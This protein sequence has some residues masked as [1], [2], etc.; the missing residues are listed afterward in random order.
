MT[1]FI[2]YLV[3]RGLVVNLISIFLLAIGIYAAASINR[4]AFPNVNLDTILVNVVY[5]G[6][7]PKEVEQLVVTPI[8]QELRTINGIDKMVSMSFPGSGRITLE[9]DPDAKNRDLLTSDISLAVSRAKLPSELPFEPTVL[10]IDGAIFPIIRLALSAPVSDLELKRLSLDIRDD[11]LNVKG[12]AKVTIL[13][14]RKAEIRIEVDPKKLAQEHISVTDIQNAIL[15]WNINTAGGDISTREGQKVVRIVGEFLTPE[16]A[17]NLVIRTNARGDSLKVKDVATV[18]ESLTVPSVTYDVGGQPGLSMLVL[19][20]SDADIINTVDRVHEY[21]DTVHEVYGDD[22]NINGFQDFSKF[23]RMRLGVL[24]NNGKVGL[25]LVFI[26]LLFFLRFSV[27]MMA[28]IG[29]PIIFMSGI[30]LLYISGITLN[31]ISM[32]GFIMV[33]GMLVDDAILI[34]ENITFHMEKGM[35]PKM[36]AVTGTLELIGPVT[37]SILTTIAAFIPMMFMSGIIGKF[38]ISIPIVVVLM[39]TLSWL[40]TFFILPSHVA[41]FTNPDKH[42]KERAWLVALDTVYS[43]LLTAVIKFRWITVGLSVVVLVLA[44]SL[45]KTMPFQLFPA[46][47]VEEFM[48]RVTAKPGTSLKEMRQNMRD[49]NSVLI[50]DL[51]PEHVQATLLTT[52]EISMDQGDPLT[53]RGSRYGQIR[54]IYSSAVGRPNHDVLDDMQKAEQNVTAQF[55]DLDIAFTA[56]QPGPPLGRP[57]EAEISSTNEK[58]SNA[59]AKKLIDYLDKIDGITSIDSGLKRG[60]DEIHVVLDRELATYAGVN[61]ASAASV[62]RAATGGLVVSY[63]HKDSEEIDITIR[64]PES[65]GNGL[66]ILKAIQIPNRTDGLVPLSKIAN[67]EVKEGFTTIR[68]KDAIRIVN[69]T[70]DIDASIITSKALNTLV[71]ENE[72][73]WLGELAKSVTVN[74]G[75]EEEKNLES[76]RSLAIAFMFALLAIFFILAIQFN[77]LAYPLIVML[78][79]PFGAIGIIFSVYLHDIFWKPMPLSF[80]TMLGMVALTGVVVNSSLILLVFIQRALKEGIEVTKAIIT[81]GRRRLRAVLLTATTTIVGLLPTAYGWGGSDPF[82]QPMALSLSSGLAFAT[83]ITLIS[84]PATFAVGVDI[85]NFFVKLLKRGG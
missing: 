52:G 45:A 6:A 11:L 31:M 85:K 21:M 81:A 55:K 64:Y 76:T 25:L 24:T 9:V 8:E 66:E 63:A 80:F 71:R 62:V 1:A 14:D 83:L 26:S 47:G 82:V 49:I 30:Y 16:D 15:G 74:Y 48:V 53:Q 51:A 65:D 20:K 56:V 43:R 73:E 44:V 19:K 34:G 35:A 79:I 46:A 3:H 27:A 38:V 60:D 13:G 68:H 67:F 72:R 59:A 32:M 22:V 33:L 84:I 42:P 2:N 4:E 61:L 70:A 17:G 5:P 50:S 10:E 78:A 41:H 77:N 37:A 58:I 23:T 69:I 28:T 40:E 36:A 39:L 18:I 12:V 7:S 54:A 29:L 75:G 57:L